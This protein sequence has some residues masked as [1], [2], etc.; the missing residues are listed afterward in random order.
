MGALANA[1]ILIRDT[2]F[3]D[4][5]MAAAAYQARLVILEPDT[6]PDHTVRYDLAT[7]VANDPINYR[8]RFTTYLATD[9]AICTK[10][11]TPA[12]VTEQTVLDKVA[13]IWTTVSKMGQT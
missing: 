6:T 5:C 3:Q 13:E 10:G 1:A 12:A 9:P 8:V 11:S 2:T 4:W 7:S